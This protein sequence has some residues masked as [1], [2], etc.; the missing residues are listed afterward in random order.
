MAEGFSGPTC[1]A[2]RCDILSRPPAT[3]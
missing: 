1:I 2:T 3:P